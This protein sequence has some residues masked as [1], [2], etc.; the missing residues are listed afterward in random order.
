MKKNI[1]I[2][3][4]IAVSLAALAIL[5][6]DVSF[7]AAEYS[8]GDK[9]AES[10]SNTQS[11]LHYDCVLSVPFSPAIFSHRDAPSGYS[12]TTSGGMR[13]MQKYSTNTFVKGGRFISDASIRSFQI[14]LDMFPSGKLSADHN[15]IRLCKL[16][17]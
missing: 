1:F 16:L 3:T 15:F 8:Y 11:G 14:V 13:L 4:L 6:I 17:I 5:R 2:Y 9:S 10:L 12:R 7:F